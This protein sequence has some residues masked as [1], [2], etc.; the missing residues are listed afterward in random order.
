MPGLVDAVR[1]RLPWRGSEAIPG[2]GRRL[3]VADHVAVPL[4][5]LGATDPS[6]SGILTPEA[7]IGKAKVGIT[8]QFLE[9]AEVYDGK[10]TLS[11]NFPLF[12]GWSF[13][14]ALR[15]QPSPLVLDIGSGSGS[16]STT[17]CL[18]LL[19]DCRIVATDLSPQ[20]LRLLR[21]YIAQNRLEDRVACICVDAMDDVFRPGHFDVVL[22]SAILHHLM[23]PERALVAAFRALRSGGTAAFY[24]PFEGHGLLIWAYKTI[25]LRAERERLALPEPVA[26]F[27]TGMVVD[28]E[29]RRGTDKSASRFQ[30]MDDK[31]LFTRR[32]VETVAAKIGFRQVSVI[33]QGES[34]RRGRDI[35]E[36]YFGQVGLA[37][38]DLPDWGWDEI[39]AIDAHFSTEMKH[40][41]PLEATVVLRK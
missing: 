39:D 12:T 13:D 17:P 10:Y 30:Y 35:T 27:I 3:H 41:A 2:P 11:E 5:D 19:P 29:A 37:R 14:D 9:N 31:W 20:L 26:K 4:V 28:F 8:A 24:E 36:R 6:Y 22:G 16:N 25:L 1:R 7:D 21:R 32:Y 34:E 40:D 23:D 18:S 38:G 15:A 33:P